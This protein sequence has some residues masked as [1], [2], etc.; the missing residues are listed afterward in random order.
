MLQSFTS[1]Q[2][3][4]VAFRALAMIA[5]MSPPTWPLV[6]YTLKCYFANEA[7]MPGLSIYNLVDMIPETAIVLL[8]G[9][10]ILFAY[11]AFIFLCPG[12]VHL[13]TWLLYDNLLVESVQAC[14][15]TGR[16]LAYITFGIAAVLVL[17]CFITY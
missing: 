2:K 14:R 5:L 1:A 6:Y 16:G 11:E 3:G 9:L 17:V 13:I 7:T 15:K 12:S 4:S 10:V 8:L